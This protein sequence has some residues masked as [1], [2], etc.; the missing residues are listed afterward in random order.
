MWYTY[1][2]A[3]IWDYDRKELEKTEAGRIK[4]L[5]R[6]L[7]YGPEPEEKIKLSD[8]KNIGRNYNYFLK[9]K[10]YLSYSYG[11]N[12]SVHQKQAAVLKAFSQNTYITNQGYF[13]GGT[14]LS[15]FY[16][17]HRD[18]EDIDIF[19]KNRWE[20]EK[21]IRFYQT[22]LEKRNDHDSSG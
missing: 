5:E 10:A 18:S 6:T 20:S 9:L 22:S 4:I 16:L 13:T 17:H 19:S 12:T 11:A 21:Y 1:V 7:N 3:F 2:M 15:S 8:V 14:A